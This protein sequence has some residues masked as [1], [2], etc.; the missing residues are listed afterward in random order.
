VIVASYYR[1]RAAIINLLSVDLFVRT[2]HLRAALPAV[3]NESC[4]GHHPMGID[5][6]VK[7]ILP[8]ALLNLQSSAILLPLSCGLF[9]APDV[10]VANIKISIQHFGRARSTFRAAAVYLCWCRNCFRSGG[11]GSC[12]ITSDGTSHQCSTGP[13]T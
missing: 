1:C 2:S 3:Q 10:V 12:C 13:A 9:I 7:G 11:G 8:G 5:L 6:F 4:T